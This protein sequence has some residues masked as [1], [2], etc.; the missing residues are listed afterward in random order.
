MKIARVQYSFKESLVRLSVN[1]DPKCLSENSFSFQEQTCL[2]ALLHSVTGWGQLLG[3]CETKQLI[4]EY[5]QLELLASC[6]P[7]SHISER[8]IL[9]ATQFHPLSHTHLFFHTGL[10]D[11]FFIIPMGWFFL[12][13]LSE[14][15]RKYVADHCPYCSCFQSSS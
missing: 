12:K 10:G 7:W 4:S 15:E 3:I 2:V 14:E 13:R 1:L 8:H 11:N 5:S 6:S 9:M